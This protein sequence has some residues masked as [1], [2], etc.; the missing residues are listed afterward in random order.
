MLIGNPKTRSG[1]P[2]A[3]DAFSIQVGLSSNS[4]T[5]LLAAENP[6]MPI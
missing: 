5:M 3:L 4:G 2:S 1:G 6:T